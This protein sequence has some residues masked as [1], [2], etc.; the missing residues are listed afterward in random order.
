MT[1]GLN[2]ETSAGALE[3]GSDRVP[4]IVMM[5]AAKAAIWSRVDV[6]ARGRGVRLR[7][8]HPHQA[9]RHDSMGCDR[10]R[11]DTGERMRR[12][13]NVGS[14]RDWQDWTPTHRGGLTNEKRRRPLLEWAIKIVDD[15]TADIDMANLGAGGEA[16]FGGDDFL[17]Y[18]QDSRPQRSAWAP[19][20]YQGKCFVCKQ[21]YVGARRSYFC[22]D[23]AYK[24][25]K[26]THR[27]GPS[28]HTVILTEHLIVMLGDETR[29]MH[30][31][32]EGMDGAKTV[33]NR[34]KFCGE[35]AMIELTIS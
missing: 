12:R 16:L 29:E 13:K 34:A 20:G 35:S 24:S 2:P 5:A 15:A 33:W 7:P 10:P 25:W 26:P 32:V 4:S 23:C 3:P 6:L 30:C 9:Q 19:G 22:P 21:G 17:D 1:R 14:W 11:H 18:K 31:V 8:R 28:G 27:H